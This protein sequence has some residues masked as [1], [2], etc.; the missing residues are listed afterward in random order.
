MLVFGVFGAGK[1]VFLGTAV[2]DERTMPALFV[3][4][5]SNYWSI[6]SKVEEFTLED[7]L[8]G[9]FSKDKLTLL[10]INSWNEYEKLIDYLE[11]DCHFKSIMVDSISEIN[12]L[13]LRE[14]VEHHPIKAMGEKDAPEL[15][16]YNR[17]ATNM[18]RTIR[19]LRDLPAHLF[20]SAQLNE[21][22]DEDTGT[23]KMKPNLIGKLAY[24]V[25]SLVNVVGFLQVNKDG[26]R[27]MK[28]QPTNRITA[29]DN[30]EGGKLGREIDDCSITDILNKLE[31]TN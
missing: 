9:M 30:T 3:E 27:T 12:Y 31:V 23:V 11:D 14:C 21:D 20:L 16:H 29:K 4:F 5:E 22:K 28:F 15:I 25:C 7:V 26:S 17:S 18:R 1:T 19:E 8:D 10:H 2:K 6:E 13:N 24:E